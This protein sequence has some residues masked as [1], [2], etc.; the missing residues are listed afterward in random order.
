MSVVAYLNIKRVV[1]NGQ[2]SYEYLCY[3]YY[4]MVSTAEKELVKRKRRVLPVAPSVR[5]PGTSTAC[6]SKL[7]LA[8]SGMFLQ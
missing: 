3:D 7:N 6:L 1:N 2:I 4:V 8:N 5:V